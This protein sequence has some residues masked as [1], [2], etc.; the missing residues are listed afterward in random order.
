LKS[1]ESASFP[2][3]NPE[4]DSQ[5]CTQACPKQLPLTEAISDINRDVFVQQVKDFFTR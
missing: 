2:N 1:E 4:F 5:N 3:P